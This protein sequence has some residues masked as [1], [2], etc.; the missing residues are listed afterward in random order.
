MPTA[1]THTHIHP[2][3]SLVWFCTFLIRSY[4]EYLTLL[5]EECFGKSWMDIHK[6]I[7]FFR[8]LR[9]SNNKKKNSGFSISVIIWVYSLERPLYARIP[10]VPLK[11]G[12]HL[13]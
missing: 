13:S 8:G 5:P 9:L 12:M 6:G 3:T 2:D 1:H 7:F 4:S 10:V 11:S